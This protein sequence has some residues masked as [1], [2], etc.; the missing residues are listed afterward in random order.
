[1]SDADYY[2]IAAD[3]ADKP[4]SVSVDKKTNYISVLSMYSTISARFGTKVLI[5]II[6]TQE[7]SRSY[8]KAMKKSGFESYIIFNENGEY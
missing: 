7:Y 1:M 4:F 5:P 3:T 8:L 2:G 6:D